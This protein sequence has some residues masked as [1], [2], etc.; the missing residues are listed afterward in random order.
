MT[1][2][3]KAQMTNYEVSRYRGYDLVSTQEDSKWRVSVYSTRADLPILAQSKG[4]STELNDALV[5]AKQ[6]IDRI[7]GF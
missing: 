4:T 7:L 5:A 1:G 3:G 6:S 2:A